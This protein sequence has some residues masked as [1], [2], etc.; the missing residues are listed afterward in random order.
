MTTVRVLSYNIRALRD[1]SA[2]VPRVIRAAGAD[3]VCIQ[4]APRFLRWR[5]RC[6][7]LARLSGMVVVS[8]GRVCGANLVL[9]SLA[10]SVDATYDVAFTKDRRLHQ[11][12]TSIALLALR[13]SRFAVAGTHLDLVEAP[14][15]RH[16]GELHRA[17]TQR[18]P[19]E[20]P[21]AV[22]GDMNDV[23]GSATWTALADGG[24]D[25]FAEVG[26]GPG[27]T[28]SA[29]EPVR[30]IDGVF[31]DRRARIVSA[32]VLDTPDTRVASDHRPVLVEFELP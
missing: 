7:A 1:D 30:R 10:V 23:P 21:A 14:R 31:V 13:G 26:V 6:A 4:E 28:Y 11:R 8:G 15:L 3:V 20:V 25:A 2:A 22:L 29:V 24:V 5:S 9:S 19:A 12:G 32:E 27:H 18:V 16:V 17:L